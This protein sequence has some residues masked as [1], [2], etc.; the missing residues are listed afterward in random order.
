[1]ISAHTFQT[2]DLPIDI[3]LELIPHFH[4]STLIT[5]R[6]V[7]RQWRHLAQVSDLHPVRRGMLDLYLKAI[8]SPYFL[9]SR[10]WTVVNLRCFDRQ[11]YLDALLAQ[12]DWLPMD[13]SMWLLEWPARAALAYMWPGLPESY[14]HPSP[15][16]SPCEN[17]FGV[18]SLSLF[19]PTLFTVKLESWENDDDPI[20]IT[21]VPALLLWDDCGRTMEWLMLDKAYGFR[22]DRAHQILPNA[23]AIF[24]TSDGIRHSST[25]IHSIQ[26]YHRTAPPTA[27]S[28]LRA[29]Y[30]E[31]PPSRPLA[32][33]LDEFQQSQQ[34]A[35][36]F[37]H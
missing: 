11:A 2:K 10:P 26:L 28:V 12:Y 33:D 6:G 22:G 24:T 37:G 32:T 8:K 35:Q 18:N 15:N 20:K 23:F 27:I 34:R 13:F 7:S 29:R 5:I 14:E 36:T 17:I 3:I 1:M 16:W 4:L 25:S 30:A 19:P 21:E 31:R 9:S